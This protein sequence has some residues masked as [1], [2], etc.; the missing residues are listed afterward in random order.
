V[1]FGPCALRISPWRLPP[2]TLLE[3]ASPALSTA[4]GLYDRTGTV[5][6][7]GEL[8]V[9]HC[10]EPV[11]GRRAFVQVTTPEHVA[12]IAILG[13]TG[14]VLWELENPPLEKMFCFDVAPYRYYFEQDRKVDE[15]IQVDKK[16][17]IATV[18]RPGRL[19]TSE[20]M[21]LSPPSP[22]PWDPPWWKRLLRW[23]LAGFE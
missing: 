11:D 8:Y 10:G 18:L 9:L 19:S 1:F 22:L 4:D 14:N 17:F 5:R 12:R 3:T 21:G 16:P 15:G 20:Q 2:R 6:H 13:P 23:W 7:Q